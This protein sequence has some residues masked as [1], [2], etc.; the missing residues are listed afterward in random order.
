M[1]ACKLLLGGAASLLG[2]AASFCWV[3]QQKHWPGV[4]FACGCLRWTYRGRCCQLPKPC[5]AWHFAAHACTVAVKA[6]SQ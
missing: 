5:L 1:P 4:A 6:A 2:D 3:M